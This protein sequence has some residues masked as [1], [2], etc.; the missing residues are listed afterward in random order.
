[1]SV[2]VAIGGTIRAVRVTSIRTPPYIT[3]QT[4][5]RVRAGS[6]I[7]R[8]PVPPIPCSI[9]VI[10][11]SPIGTHDGNGMRRLSI[12]CRRPLRVVGVVTRRWTVVSVST[13]CA[14]ISIWKRVYNEIEL[15]R[16]SSRKNGL[17]TGV[18]PIVITGELAGLRKSPDYET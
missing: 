2:H 11:L 17:H 9:V 14:V 6:R 1:M 3:A 4:V 7:F 16:I 13:A 15:Q 12:R 5:Y 18:V 8:S 10:Y